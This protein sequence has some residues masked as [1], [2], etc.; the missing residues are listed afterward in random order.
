VRQRHRVRVPRLRLAVLAAVAA[1][2]VSADAFPSGF[3]IMT[4][5]A[6][7]TGMGLAY[8]G[9]GGDPTAIFYNPA[10]IGWMT[11]FEGYA[12]VN[13]LTR[14][15]GEFDGANPFPGAGDVEH[16]VDNWYFFPD[17]FLVIPLTSELNVGLAG[18]AQ[19][20]LGIKW[21][22]PNE[23]FPG[24][25]NAFSGRFISQNAVIQSYDTNLVLTYR[26][27]QQLSISAG[28]VLRFSKVQLERNQG[29]I[30]PQTGSFVDAAHVKL[31]S[32]LMDNSGWGWNVGLM[33][34]PIES[35]SIGAAYRS[36][37]NVDYEG[38]ATF[39]TRDTGNAYLNQIVAASLPTGNPP[40]TTSIDFPSTLNLGVGIQLPAQFLLALEA[41]WTEWSRFASL[42]IRFPTLP[43]RDLFRPTL[44]E[45]TWAYR[46][47]LEKG[48]GNWAVR[49]GYYYDNT[50]Q[51]DFDVSPILPDSDR[52]V[53]TGGFGYNTERWGFDVAALYLVFKDRS[54]VPPTPQTD[55]YFGTYSENALIL[56]AGLRVAF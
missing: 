47:G 9:V 52:N 18:F 27:F 7:A 30:D 14:T 38:E 41:D 56:T 25:P 31:N 28:A 46:V 51:P 55:N 40:V 16:E 6:R 45:D 20:G 39:T 12:G 32:K 50:P 24:D 2:F 5:G 35:I 36:K 26:L 13:F 4:H 11:H 8:A 21:E 3:Q 29:I 23:E 43:G 53:Y 15:K 42:D 33:F 49:V 34:K 44:W 48:F 22:N 1:L 10:G 17:G 54:V 19:Y 37:I